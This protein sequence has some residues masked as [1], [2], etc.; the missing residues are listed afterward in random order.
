MGL[1]E[2]HPLLVLPAFTNSD[3]TSCLNQ[4]L[5][6]DLLARKLIGFVCSRSKCQ[7][8]GANDDDCFYYYKKKFSTLD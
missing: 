3:V 5:M 8:V 4:I 2:R 1:P 7:L 6:F